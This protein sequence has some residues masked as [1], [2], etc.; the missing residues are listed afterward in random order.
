M[1][2]IWKQWYRGNVNDFHFYDVKLANGKT[3][4]KERRTLNMPK[5]VCE[6]FS[7]LLWSEKVEIKLDTKQ[8]TDRLWKVLDSKENSFSINISEFIEK[9]YALGTMVTIEY[10]KKG[11]TII[12]YVDG[13]VV[14]PY[15]YTNS[16]INGLITVSR[17]TEGTESK[18]KYYTLLTYH[19]YE[20]GKYIKYN[21]LYISKNENI[22]VYIKSF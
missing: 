15:K 8:K 16:Y 17:S 10:K 13:D 18:K 9:E 14:L 1:M 6:D 22:F 2:A 4:T 5:K 11:K 12:D 19:E 7:N 3:C 20:D 21:E